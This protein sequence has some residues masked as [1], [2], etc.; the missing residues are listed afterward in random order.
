MSR[1]VLQLIQSILNDMDSEPINALGE[2]LESEQVASI[3]SDTFQDIVYTEDL[4]EHREILKLTAASDTAAPT[5]FSYADNVIRIHRVWYDTQDNV[6]ATDANRVYLEVV[7]CDPLDFIDRM[8]SVGS[9]GT[10]YDTILENSS[11]TTLRIINNQHPSFYTSFD[12]KTIVMNSYNSAYDT[13]LQASKV[14]AYGAVV[15]TIDVTDGAHVVDLSPAHTQYLLRE[16]T[17]R[18][19]E[20]LKGGTTPKME[21][22]TRRVRFY[23]QNDRYRTVRDNARND[24]GRR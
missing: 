9:S 18:C 1:T 4:P 3:L 11:G 15:P 6:T 19:F 14:R 12:N 21:Q 8:D 10:D 24:Y 17:S 16:S 20:T 7:W 13:T 22:N 5:E 2:T 23:L